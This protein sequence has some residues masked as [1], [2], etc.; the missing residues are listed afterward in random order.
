VASGLSATFLIGVLLFFCSR[1]ARKRH[2]KATQ[3]DTFEIGGHMADPILAILPPVNR[4]PS[5]YSGGA[6]FQT[7]PVAPLVR[8]PLVVINKSPT[9]SSS[10]QETVVEGADTPGTD[11][12]D[13][14]TGRISQRAASQ[15]LPEKPDYSIYPEPLRVERSLKGKMND[16]AV[17]EGNSQLLDT[18]FYNS[19]RQVAQPMD[20]SERNF[21]RL[22]Q[23]NP[24]LR[25]PAAPRPGM[26]GLGRARNL[27]DHH[28]NFSLQ[29]PS[30]PGPQRNRERRPDLQAV[31]NSWRRPNWYP[32]VNRN[33]T[34]VANMETAVDRQFPP[35]GMRNSWRSSQRLNGRPSASNRRSSNRFSG[36]SDTSFESLEYEEEEEEEDDDDGYGNWSLGTAKQLSPVKEY[37]TP[38]DGRTVNGVQQLGAIR[39]SPI[40]YPRMPRSASVSRD[41]EVIPRPKAALR[42]ERD[43]DANRQGRSRVPVPP[44]A[45]FSDPYY[46]QVPMVLK[47]S[48]S[49]SR[50]PS[51]ASSLLARRVGDIVADK[52]EAEFQYSKTAAH[53]KRGPPKWKVIEER[54]DPRPGLYDSQR[55]VALA[56]RTPPNQAPGTGTPDSQQAHNLTPSRRGEDLYL[57]VD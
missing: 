51:P 2:L 33:Q 53:N 12:A 20:I 39:S 30:M 13:S 18:P 15:L 29:V 48:P 43:G 42:Y 16:G 27:T 35:N 4:S 47:E 26:Y 36:Y 10:T 8:G 19:L 50:D 22:P 24:N 37:S 28:Q 40:R 49:P 3:R 45:T 52:M 55:A 32:P 54:S 56:P 21:R 41:A 1:K 17:F 44:T 31:D 11:Q 23:D 46:G 34:Y 9:H 38:P 5:P 14:P 6:H 25:L 7:F 57:S